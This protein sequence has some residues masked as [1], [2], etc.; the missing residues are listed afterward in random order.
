MSLKAEI[1]AA[2]IAREGGYSNNLADSGGET[3]YGI[4]AGVARANG[5]TGPMRDMPRA[6]AERILAIQYCDVIALDQLEGLSVPIAAE[7]ADT[8]VNMGPAVAGRFLQRALNVFNKGGTLYPDLTVDGKP[9]ARTVAALR[10]FLLLRGKDGEAVMLKAL[11]CLQGARYIELA[12]GRE[13]DE[14]FVYGWIA[15]RVEI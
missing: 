2:I 12:E 11:N 4:T 15:N 10:S 13:K 7:M 6:T 3:M 1:V 14:A 5:Y 9:G 8:A